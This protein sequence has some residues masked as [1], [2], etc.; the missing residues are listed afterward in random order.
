M[1]LFISFMDEEIHIYIVT[2]SLKAGMVEQ[3]Q[4]F[5]A[6]KRLGSHVPATTNSKERLV[7]R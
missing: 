5:I 7:A 2:Q 3:E 1:I 4:K 6:E